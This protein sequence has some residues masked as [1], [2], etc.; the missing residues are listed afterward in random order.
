M[1]KVNVL[2]N[3]GLEVAYADAM[4]VPLSTFIYNKKGGDTVT[5]FYVPKG[6]EVKVIKFPRN[7]NKFERFC[8]D[9]DEVNYIDK[10][11]AGEFISFDLKDTFKLRDYQK[12]PVAGVLKDLTATRD[13]ATVLQA[14]PSFGKTFILP[15]IVSSLQKRTLVLVDRDLLRD[16]MYEEF[17]DN[18]TAIVEKLSSKTTKLGDVNIATFQ[19]LLK[20]KR[21]MKLLAKEIGFIIVDECHV[22]PADKFLKVIS[23]LPA[24]YRLGLS[25]TPTRSDGLTSIITDTFG[26]NKVIG[27]NPNNLKVYNVVVETKIPVFF[28]NKSEYAKQFVKA[29]TSPIKKGADTPIQLAVAAGIKLR[30]RNRKVLVYVTYG[31]LQELVKKGFEAEGY[32]VAII[33]GKTPKVKRAELIQAFQEGKID[34]L[35]SGVILQKGV[36]IH[37]LDTIINLAPQNKENLEQVKGRLRRELEGK[38]EPMFIYFTFGGKLEY[39]NATTVQL[40]ADSQNKGDKFARVSVN[41]FKKQLGV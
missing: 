36:S 22:A 37:A 12:E 8:V 32:S 6:R 11:V 23:A 25:A 10:R 31:K 24:K 21:L 1:R 18:S 33:Q 26:Y 40:L 41:G 34:I 30:Q 4:T 9:A 27:A 35:V 13:N 17:T 16:Q 3:G 5:S 38:G 28:A 20:N 2:I 15:Y 14:E 7:R 29:M 19:L 39:S